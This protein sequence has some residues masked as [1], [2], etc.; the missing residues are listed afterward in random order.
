MPTQYLGNIEKVKAPFNRAANAS[1]A[2]SE[3]E[4][5]DIVAFLHTLSDGFTAAP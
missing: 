4:I 1:P 5:A 2:L 3:L